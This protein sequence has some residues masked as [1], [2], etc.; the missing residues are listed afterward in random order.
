MSKRENKPFSKKRMKIHVYGEGI[1]NY[2]Y[3]DDTCTGCG[4]CASVCPVDNI[5]VDRE[6]RSIAL[7]D[8]CFSCFACLHH[9]PSNAIHINGEV[10][11]NRYINRHIELKEIIEA[12]K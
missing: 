4:V 6:N 9:C 8:K 12:N 11:N 1:E 3:V 10:N 5:E 2:I 7:Q